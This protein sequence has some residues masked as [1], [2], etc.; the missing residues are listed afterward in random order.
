MRIR[1]IVQTRMKS[2][3][4]PGKVLAKIGEMTVLEHIAARLKSLE[5]LGV[6]TVFALA[7]EGDPTLADFLREKGLAFMVG[8]AHNV[9][10][11]YVDAAAD[12][13][14]TDYVIR[15]TGD[16]PFI[17][18]DRLASL[19]HHAR[20]KSFD[21]GYTAELPLGQGTELISV[22]ALRSVFMR[23]L[24]LKAGDESP[25]KPHHTEHV[26]TFIRENPHLY[27]IF[28]LRLDETMSEEGAAERVRG[29]RVTIDEQA[30]LEVARKIFEHFNRLGKPHFGALDVIMLAKN[31]P[32]MFA[33]NSAVIQKPATSYQRNTK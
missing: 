5:S 9:L 16:N 32:E 10:R 11:R 28:P 18:K 8:D 20:T 25:L 26:T 19:I 31:S 2:E 22:A 24:P 3:R 30:D 6:E 23:A 12:L 1:A 21:Y 17:D 33:A 13:E 4:L 14:T 29:I 15:A 27:E 7:E